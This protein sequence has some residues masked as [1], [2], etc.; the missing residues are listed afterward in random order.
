MSLQAVPHDSGKQYLVLFE[1][2]FLNSKKFLLPKF[3]HIHRY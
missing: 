1:N 3:N 2:F